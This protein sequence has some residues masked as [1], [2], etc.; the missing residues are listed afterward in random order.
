M[1]VAAA[2]YATVHECQAGTAWLAKKL[3][4]RGGVAVLNSKVNPHTSTHHL[5]LDEAIQLMTI[6]GDYRILQAVA[7]QCGFI[8]IRM[9]GTSTDQEISVM[10]HVL[11]IGEHKG[12]L[13]A[14]IKE[15]FADGVVTPA[16]AG[17]FN[18][19]AQ[20]ICAEVM[21]LANC[22]TNLSNKKPAPAST[23]AGVLLRQQ[24]S[25]VSSV[26]Y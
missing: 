9:P 6:T 26:N 3:G 4:I 12:D 5:R 18:S 25:S 17:L 21:S 8:C 7:F 24:H 23:S 1:N 15:I 16:E 2:A 11:E 14:T 10:H 20:K 13:C 22:L 19:L